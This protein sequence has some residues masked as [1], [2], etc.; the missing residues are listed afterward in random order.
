MH[1]ILVGGK[2]TRYSSILLS[3]PKDDTVIQ[4]PPELIDGDHPPLFKP[5]DYESYIKYCFTEEG[6]KANHQLDEFCGLKKKEEAS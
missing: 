6:Q 3:I 4:A 1:R 5:Y 2:E